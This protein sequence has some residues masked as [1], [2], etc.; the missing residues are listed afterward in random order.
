MGRTSRN[1]G[2]SLE[3]CIEG[4]HPG[5]RTRGSKELLGC[6]NDDGLGGFAPAVH[7]DFAVRAYRT[8]HHAG[9]I[10][11]R[12]HVALAVE[13]DYPAVAVLVDEL[14]H[15]HIVR[16][17]LERNVQVANSLA[18]VSGDDVAHEKFAGAGG[19]NSAAFVVG[20]GAGT[21]DG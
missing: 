13:S 17:F 6:R 20:V 7:H 2:T 8:G 16:G 15:Y 11:R 14:F 5:T 19:G 18:D 10:E 12:G 1:R 21:N 3:T 9:G 4:N